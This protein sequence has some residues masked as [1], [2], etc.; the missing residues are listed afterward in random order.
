MT[1]ARG[2]NVGIL[3]GSITGCAVAAE[4]ARAGCTVTVLEAGGAEPVDRGAGIGLPPS[5]VRT[6]VDHGLVD[7]DLP[8]IEVHRF[9]HLVRDQREERYGQLSWEQRGNLALLEW[10][11]LY[12]NLRRR[13]PD[14]AYETSCNVTALRERPDGTVVVD[15]GDRGTRE[16][17][18]VVCA[19]GHRSLGRR[20]LF[21]EATV[22]YAGYVLWRGAIE[23]SALSESTPLEGAVAWPHYAGG[24][25][26]FFLVPGA[27]GSTERGRRL[28][29][30][31]LYL[32]VSEVERAE[33]V[34]GKDPPAYDGPLPD[35]RDGKLK[36]WVP[37]VLPDYYAEI[38]QKTPRTFA[39]KIHEAEVPAYHRGHVCLAGDAAA[40]ARPHTG[41]GVLKG[42]SDAISLGETLTGHPPLDEALALWSEEQTAFG[43]EL[44]KLGNQVGRALA[45]EVPDGAT[46]DAEARARLFSSVVTVPSE[47]FGP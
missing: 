20:T 3:G 37:L 29:N 41:T 30:W 13:V 5:L 42:I 7:A 46:A 36:S 44:V 26:P 1:R 31:G 27:D 9:P 18:L 4:L 43:N 28:V 19:D 47:V 39:Q 23:E 15:L 22:R 35:V 2:F 32:R 11:T 24:Y 16:F 10:G 40:L 34:T 45:A 12:R 38:V 21:P 8:T 25:G 6:L 33:L 14:G 17:D